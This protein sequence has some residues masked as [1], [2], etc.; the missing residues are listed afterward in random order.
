MPLVF[1]AIV[2]AALA[3]NFTLLAAIAAGRLS[4]GWGQRVL[5]AVETAFFV[6]AVVAVVGAGLAVADSMGWHVARRDLRVGLVGAL[7]F[8]LAAGAGGILT[9]LEYAA[10]GRRRAFGADLRGSLWFGRSGVR[11]WD[12]GSR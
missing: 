10:A 2:S 4:K 3:S 12:G 5:L 7:A 11:R 8:A 9:Y 6:V 1:A